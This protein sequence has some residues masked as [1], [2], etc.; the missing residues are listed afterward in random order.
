MRD[1]GCQKKENLQVIRGGRYA[2]RPARIF[3]AAEIRLDDDM[4]E[5]VGAIRGDQGQYPARTFQRVLYEEAFPWRT[6]ARLFV[7]ARKANAP[8]SQ[9]QRIIE[10]LSLLLDE[11]YQNTPNR[12][13]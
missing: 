8:K 10:R 1:N 5:I 12:A 2:T 7:K 9:S 4:K 13:A 6:M 3:T 11:L